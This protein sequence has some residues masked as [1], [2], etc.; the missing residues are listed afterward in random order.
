MNASVTYAEMQLHNK[1][2]IEIR[3]QDLNFRPLNSIRCSYQLSHW[4]SGIEAEDRYIHA[5]RNFRK[6][7]KKKKKKKKL[8]R[9]KTFTVFT[10]ATNCA[11][12]PPPPNFTNKTS[13]SWIATKP[14]YSQKFP[15]SNIYCYNVYP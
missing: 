15:S 4:S 3:L 6:L 7:V 14:R 8:L 13:L 10:G 5:V 12:K 11:T 2:D 1:K 9:E